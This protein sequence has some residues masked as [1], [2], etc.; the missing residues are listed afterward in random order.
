MVPAS[1]LLLSVLQPFAVV[2]T[3]PTFAHALTLV[4]G[5]LLA[6]GRRTVTAALRALGRGDER[7]FT[8]YHRVLNRGSWSPLQV[9]RILLQLVVS[10]LLAP[11]APLVLLVDSTLERRWGRK[12]GL[13]GRY[14]DAVRSQL[15]H[16]V[17]S[18]GIQWL[19]L[20]LLVMLL[21]PS[22]WSARQWALPVLTVPTRSPALSRK[23]QKRHRTTP[24]YAELLIALV[25]RW[26][27]GRAVVLIGDSAFATA[28]L[29][30]T[31]RRLGVRLVSRL[32]LTAQ[33]YDPV[34]PQPRGKAGVKPKKGPRQP[35]LEA[36]LADQTPTAWDATAIDWYAG[37]RLAMD[38][39]TGTALWHRDGEAPLPV[40][41]VLLRDPSGKRQ[42]VALFCTDQRASVH[43][44][45]A[46]YVSR[47]AVEVTFEEA[48]AHLG[49]QTQRHWNPLAVARTT[50]CLLGLFSLTVL[51]A[52]RLGPNQLT[53][54]QAAW[55]AKAEPTFVDALAAVR[56]HLW[57]EANAPTP[58][59]AAATA[60]SRPSFPTLLDRLVEAACYAA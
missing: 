41:W 13:K 60:N 58:V 50:P 34:P 59:A 17:T 15:G 43:Q 35:K 56:R 57:V 26:Q 46:W 38:L 24:E 39:A 18:E 20:M 3:G 11:D 27:P 14:H 5:T 44:I 47:W 52:Y 19:C 22:P 40:R 9:S 30:L 32:L 2:F 36:R 6:T 49:F 54:R 37:Q 55:Y 42:P 25:R 1:A 16:T 28:S 8:T 7:R 23:L 45:I 53:T 10:T 21:V 33:L 29:G 12:I 51:L 31:C 4:Q 48:R